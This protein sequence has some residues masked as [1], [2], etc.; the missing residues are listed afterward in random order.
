MTILTGMR[1]NAS[2]PRSQTPVHCAEQASAIREM[3][4]SSQ[5]AFKS[6]RNVQYAKH[7]QA[8]EVCA[9]HLSRPLQLS[10][11]GGKGAGKDER[12]AK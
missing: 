12:R 5:G 1:M 8:A 10:R 4:E 2:S 9:K 6:A 3:C 7:V 11:V